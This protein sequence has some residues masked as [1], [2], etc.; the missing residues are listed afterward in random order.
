MELVWRVKG[1]ALLL[2]CCLRKKNVSRWRL[3][4]K[5]KNTIF[6]IYAFCAFYLHLRCKTKIGFLIEQAL[7]VPSSR[8]KERNVLRGKQL[9]S[10]AVRH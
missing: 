8:T 1:A 3:E 6:V 10:A 4:E 2:T 7:T 9:I 5:S